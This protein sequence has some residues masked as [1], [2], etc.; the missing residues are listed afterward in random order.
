MAEPPLSREAFAASLG[1]SRETLDRLTVYLD[2][3]H[4]WQRAINLVGP[5]TLADPW[6]R[7]ILDSA[8]LL[9]HLPAG[10]TSLVDLGSGAGFPG[11]VLA[12]LGVPG[13]VLIE[14]DRRKAQFLREVA[15]ATGTE[16][17]VRAERIENLAGWPADVVTA[18]AL[19]P[20]PRLLPLAERFLA[21]DS[22]CL[23]L[24]GYNA[25]RELTQA[26]K[27]WHMV[28]E[29]FSSLSAPTGTVLKLRGVGRCA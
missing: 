29:M 11:M 22:V 7:H 26:L 14:S 2:L 15:R 13:V 21:A 28:P 23:F 27:S 16:V 1:V 4:R 8:Q 3:L 12:V 17:T 9:T 24:K 19:A 25:E 5:A 6:R 18:R 10:T 20:L